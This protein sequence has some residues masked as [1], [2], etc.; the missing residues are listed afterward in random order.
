MLRLTIILCLSSRQLANGPLATHTRKQSFRQSKAALQISRMR[1]Q[2]QRA[3]FTLQQKLNQEFGALQHTFAR[4]RCSMLRAAED[5]MYDRAYRAERRDGR[6]GQVYRTSKDR[7][8]EMATARQL[9]HMQ[10]S[11]RQLMKKG[12]TLRTESFRARKKWNR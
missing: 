8:E 6:A 4:G 7:A 2:G 5:L 10:E 12:R 9:L 3:N 1:S 11:T